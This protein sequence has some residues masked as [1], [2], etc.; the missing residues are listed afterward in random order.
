MAELPD[1]HV[2]ARGPRGT[3]GCAVRSRGASE[4]KDFLEGAQ[5]RKSKPALLALFQTIVNQSDDDDV[6]GPKP[7]K[8]THIHEFVKGQ[9][10]L[11]S[12]RDGSAWVLTNGDLKKSNETPKANIERAERIMQED[13]EVKQRRARLN[14]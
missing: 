6:L 5:C 2:V 12:Y 1:R 9:V 3:I 11:F 7:L 10:R 8:K 13:Q 4:A 14:C